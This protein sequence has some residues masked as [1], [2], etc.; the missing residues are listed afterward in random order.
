MAKKKDDQKAL[1][2]VG[3]GLLALFFLSRKKKPTTT[4]KPSGK[5]TP[6]GF[7]PADDDDTPPPPPPP[8]PRKIAPDFKPEDPTGPPP[9]QEPE[10]GSD[11]RFQN[12]YSDVPQV[13]RFYQIRQGD[14]PYKIARRALEKR[15]NDDLSIRLDERQLYTG[16]NQAKLLQLMTKDNGWNALLYGARNQNSSGYPESD[17]ALHIGAAW[18][19]R[20]KNAPT[21]L[22]AGE[23]VQRTIKANGQKM[24]G[25]SGNAYGLVWIPEIIVGDDFRVYEKG[26]YEDG[27]PA[28]F[29]PPD[30]R[31]KLTGAG[32]G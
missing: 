3:A 6:G 10:E 12:I 21:F 13:G 8:P 2:A 1:V 30:F 20:H 15:Q 9:E 25:A 5:K 26:E 32:I 17:T 14:N 18:L 28:S 22:R 19:P 27:T 24:S 31:S 11:E 4:A 23:K 7:K 16:A 29:P